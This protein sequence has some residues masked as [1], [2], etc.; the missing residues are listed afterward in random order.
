MANIGIMGYGVVGQATGLGFKSKGHTL[1]YYDKFK[2]TESLESVAEKSD[3]I[4]LCLPTPY[5]DNKIDLSIIDETVELLSKVTDGTD[6]IVIIKS[7]VIPGTTEGLGKK[8][9][10]TKFAFNPEF[11][12]EANANLDFLNPD[13]VV[14]GADAGEV[15]QRVVALYEKD[16]PEV[17][18]F[19]SDSKSAEMVK[20][21]ANCLL[22]TK[23]IFANEFFDLCQQLGID[24][25]KVKEMVVADR[26]IG[27][28]HL[29]I[30]A[31]F[32]GFGGKCFPKDMIAIMAVF[33][34]LG[35]DDFLLETVWQKNLKIRKE[36][37]WEE[38]PFVKS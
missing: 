32:R 11:L 22:A 3:F 18:V 25:P 29:D 23:V 17:P 10:K 5:K 19:I 8:Y 20:Y 12:T 15:G 24:Y 36:K 16:F 1:F 31:T 37:D 28:S 21:M 34:E 2:E 4:L 26:R 14:V 38:I 30:T 13:R 33:K 35:V 27:K 7:T 6:K 9:P